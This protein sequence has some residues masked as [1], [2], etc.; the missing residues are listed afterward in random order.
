MIGFVPRLKVPFWHFSYPVLIYIMETKIINQYL[1]AFNLSRIGKIRDK[2]YTERNGKET[3]KTFWC[4]YVWKK[5]G[6]MYLWFPP[7]FPMISN[8]GRR[9]FLYKWWIT[10][11]SFEKSTTSKVSESF[12]MQVFCFLSTFNKSKSQWMRICFSILICIICKC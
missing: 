3:L 1:P 8:P 10:R 9:L 7:G 4:R 6:W 5:K 11:S 12:E 2:L